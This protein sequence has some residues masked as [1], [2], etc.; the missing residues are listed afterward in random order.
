MFVLDNT[1]IALLCTYF[2]VNKDIGHKTTFEGKLT[3]CINNNRCEFDE[4]YVNVKN[5]TL[6]SFQKYST[7]RE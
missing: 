4:R 1:N 2:K 7:H 3:S 6:Q 5:S